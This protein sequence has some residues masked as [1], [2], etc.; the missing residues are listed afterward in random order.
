MASF[1]CILEGV[2]FQIFNVTPEGGLCGGGWPPPI[3]AQYFDHMTAFP[4]ITSQ[5]S[6]R[7]DVSAFIQA[8]GLAV[9]SSAPGAPVKGDTTYRPSQN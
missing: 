7:L 6:G 2:D 4:P 3:D 8:D 9:H 5:D 1:S